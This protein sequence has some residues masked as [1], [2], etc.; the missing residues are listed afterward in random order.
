LLLLLLFCLHYLLSGRNAQ[1]KIGEMGWPGNGVCGGNSIAPLRL[2]ARRMHGQRKLREAGQLQQKS[3]KRQ[4]SVSQDPPKMH[5]GKACAPRVVNTTSQN[6]D[7]PAESQLLASPARVFPILKLGVKK[8]PPFCPRLVARQVREAGKDFWFSYLPHHHRQNH[9][10]HRHWS[11]EILDPWTTPRQGHDAQNGASSRT[12]N[13]SVPHPKI[14][15][16]FDDVRGIPRA[17]PPTNWLT[18][19]ASGAFL[20]CE[21]GT[22]IIDLTGQRPWR[23]CQSR[24]SLREISLPSSSSLSPLLSLSVFTQRYNH[25]QPKHVGQPVPC[26]YGEKESHPFSVRWRPPG[27]HASVRCLAG[28]AGGATSIGG[29][30][31]GAGC[32]TTWRRVGAGDS[33][34]YAAAT[35][36]II[37]CAGCGGGG[38]KQKQH[39]Q[40]QQ[41]R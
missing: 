5:I 27:L 24:F 33:V 30:C 20:L 21:W 11:C 3:T 26:A 8:R 34:R 36:V 37:V 41:E 16:G 38:R 29:V 39:R 32:S 1:R 22:H 25:Q 15:R 7:S 28:R 6:R 4:R 12:R 10:R 35:F 31:T 17:P 2:P 14:F 19:R 40:E 9:R 13:S 18:P 23:S